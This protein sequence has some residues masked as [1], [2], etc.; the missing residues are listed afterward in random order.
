MANIYKCDNCNR[1]AIAEE[2]DDHECKTMKNYK[3]EGEL[4][5]VSDGDYWYPLKLSTTS[6][7]T[8]ADEH[9]DKE[10]Y[11]KSGS[12]RFSVVFYGCSAVVGKMYKK[13]ASCLKWLP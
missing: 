1:M 10:H 4:L 5:L 3:I 6:I 12:V 2:K 7:R 11:Q 8:T 9:P 13:V